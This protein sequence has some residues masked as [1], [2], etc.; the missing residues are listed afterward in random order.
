MK[1][2]NKVTLIGNLGNDPE[3]QTLEGG[4]KLAKFS[5]AT[6]ESYKDTKGIVQS[7]TEW[8]NIIV[9]RNLAE[10]AD[11]FLKKGSTIYLEGK[12]KTRS[13]ESKEGVRKY[14][15]EIIGDKIILLDKKE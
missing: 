6:T 13:Y 10:I 5:L 2:L 8:H 4:I 9:W 15:T 1:G 7:E 11:N 12:I 14:V 3:F